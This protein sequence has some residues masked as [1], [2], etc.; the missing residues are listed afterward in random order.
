[1]FPGRSNV[2]QLILIAAVALGIAGCSKQKSDVAKDQAP[3]PPPTDFTA[4]NAKKPG[5]VTLPS[6]LQYKIITPGTGRS[7]KADEYAVVNYIGRH[8]DGREVDNS[9]KFGKP[10]TVPIA[11]LIPGW[12]EALQLMKTGAKWDLY[13]PAKLAYGAEGVPGFIGP[14]EPLVFEVELVNIRTTKEMANLRLRKFKDQEDYRK[15]NDLFL[16]DNKTKPGI[17]TT[18]SGLQYKI[19]RKGNGPRPKLDDTVEVNYRGALIDGTEFDSS[20]ARGE[21]ATFP[22][23]KVIK[24]WTEALQ[25]MNVGA[26]W[27]IYVPASLA[28]GSDG[29]GDKI[30]PDSTLVFDI[31]LLNVK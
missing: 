29:A 21:P 5:V 20:Y 18:A 3:P 1:M 27:K 19:L 13:I 7:P 23:S 2:I 28:Y 14:N 31:E 8:A 4:E 22:V 16:A 30:R 24:G 11:G 17:V 9:Y 26:K 15:K 6:G 10:V 25:L 12:A